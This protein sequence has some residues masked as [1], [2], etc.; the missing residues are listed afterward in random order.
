MNGGTRK[1]SAPKLNAKHRG[2]VLENLELLLKSSVAPGEALETLAETAPSKRLSK[3]L[4][5]AKLAI[6]DGMPFTMALN[7]N[8]LLSQQTLALVELGEKSGNLVKNLAVAAKQE[9]KRRR[10][11]RRVQSALMYPAF[12]LSLTIVVGLGITW[13][14]MPRLADTFSSLRGEVPLLTR[15]M[16]Q[17][18]TFMQNNGVW[19]VPLVLVGLAVCVY[20]LFFAPYTRRAGRA[21]LSRTPGVSRLIH[22]VELAR[23]GYM[24][25]TLLQVGLSLTEAFE[26][27]V[28]A[29]PPG[30]YRKLY[31]YLHDSFLN[32]YS[33][34]NCLTQSSK[35][36]RILP[37]S[38][39]QLIYT[40][41]KSGSLPDVLLSV[42]AT[43]EEKSEDTTK[44]LE[45][46]LEPILLV[47][48][49]LGVLLVAIAVIV[50]I[51]N[52][53]GGLNQ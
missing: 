13:F 19:F 17:V 52:L 34:K 8:G 35:M 46:I 25:G 23:F 47:I 11:Q 36:A 28:H 44:N 24:T 4:L 50:P 39:R 20:V 45:T 12:V 51:Y 3:S 32:G 30:R 16:I 31:I 2:Y 14:I 26:L 48:V 21:L 41:E 9:E 27:V 29:T 49:W 10:F 5:N 18:G 43:Y 15:I 6:D 7:D 1:K 40:G 37:A 22:E 42:G 38:V 33:F 53:L